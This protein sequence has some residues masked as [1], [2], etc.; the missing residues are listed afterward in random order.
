ML[1][2]EVESLVPP[3]RSIAARFV[4]TAARLRRQPLPV[5]AET[6]KTDFTGLTAGE[7]TIPSSGASTCLCRA[8]PEGKTNLPV[9]PGDQ[10]DLRRAEHIADICRRFAKLGYLAV[11]RNCSRGQ[12]DPGSFGTIQELQTNIIA[13][14]P[15]AQVAGRPG[16]R[17]HWAATRRRPEPARHHRLLLG[18]THHLALHRPQPPREGRRGLVRRRW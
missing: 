18:W 3:R 5:A 7:V 15:D 12:G 17:R 1:Q 8:Q 6:I 10:R 14:V 13:K 16:R 4:K 11:A 9:V 2:P